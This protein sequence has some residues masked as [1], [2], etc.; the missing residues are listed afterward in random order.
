MNKTCKVEFEIRRAKPLAFGML[1]GPK[2][3]SIPHL[4]LPGNPVSAMVAFEEFARPAILKMLGKIKLVGF[5]END[6]TL[7]GVKDGTVAGTIVQHPY[8]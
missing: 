5:D 3:R 2:D 1:R 6:I 4:G 8:Q 7:Q